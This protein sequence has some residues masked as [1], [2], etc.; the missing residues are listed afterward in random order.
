[1]T[2]EEIIKTLYAYMKN[3]REV[4][5][6]NRKFSNNRP[7][8][9]WV[10]EYVGFCAKQYEFIDE[11]NKF[12]D[13]LE[14]FFL[15]H[16][17][18]KE[19]ADKLF[20]FTQEMEVS[21]VYD[22]VVL[23]RLV[24]KLLSFYRHENDYEKLVILNR[25]AILDEY[26]K[27]WNLGTP[28]A[29]SEYITELIDLTKY[30]G[31][32]ESEK[33]K[34]ALI[35][36]WYTYIIASYNDGC[37]ESV[38][39]MYERYDRYRA[40]LNVNG[41]DELAESD[42]SIAH[43][44][45][46]VEMNMMAVERHLGLEKNQ[47]ALERFIEQANR[48]YQDEIKAFT[49][50]WEIDPC[51]YAAKLHSMVVLGLFSM[52]EIC[53]TML[54]FYRQIIGSAETFVYNDKACKN[55]FKTQWILFHWL[56]DEF[57]EEEILADGYFRYAMHELIELSDKLYIEKL[58]YSELP[59]SAGA[60]NWCEAVMPYV[61]TDAHRRQ[62]LDHYVFRFQKRTYVH[63]VM[64]AKVSKLIAK[65][66]VEIESPLIKKCVAH[67]EGDFAD[68]VYE[69]A[70]LHDIGKM[71]MRPLT[72]LTG[73]SLTVDEQKAMHTHPQI[74]ALLL[75]TWENPGI[76]ISV[77]Q[78]HHR[79]YDGRFGYPEKYSDVGNPYKIA[80]DIIHMA[81]AIESA[82]SGFGK[83]DGKGKSFDRVMSEL[84]LGVGTQYNPDLVE[85]IGNSTELM[86]QIK[87]VAFYTR[88]E[89]VYKAYQGQE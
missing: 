25:L 59:L 27:S 2:T 14:P 72:E 77:C 74:G 71:R 5:E 19:L 28:F 21:N 23:L 44:I 75:Q 29:Y 32:M 61:D 53:D 85:L 68:V 31:Q 47:G 1:M 12:I 33:A 39:E 64:V 9:E 57:S 4:G 56:T 35:R 82:S 45:S 88:L 73:R 87:H 67:M 79:A 76:L 10:D 22:Y 49:N 60:E 20:D 52:E 18:E 42:P 43:E 34:K 58:K 7:F 8:D 16:I 63:S 48:A 78:G 50:E 24:K 86:K 54:N 84:R 65:R 38:H 37:Y 30:Y 46:L 69:A 66:L 17:R 13:K 89:N 70:L 80:V 6:Y 83:K 26:V 55:A 40:F 36:A 11:D 3:M 41:L 51:V 81:D 15:R 62:M